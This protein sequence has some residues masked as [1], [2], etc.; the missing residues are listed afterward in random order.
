M[1]VIS[2]YLKINLIIVDEKMIIQNIIGDNE[3]I[4]GN[5]LYFLEKDDHIEPIVQQGFIRNSE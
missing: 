1:Y 4:I 2:H 3:E 5:N